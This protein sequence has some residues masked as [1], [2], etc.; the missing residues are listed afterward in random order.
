MFYSVYLL[1]NMFRPTGCRRQKVENISIHLDLGMQK[2]PQIH[3][4]NA[5]QLRWIILYLIL[6]TQR[7][8]PVTPMAT[9]EDAVG[10]K[11][12]YDAV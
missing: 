10:P 8:G 2:T 1:K 3:I 12:D 5:C 7:Y 6:S 11:S 4:I 9:Q